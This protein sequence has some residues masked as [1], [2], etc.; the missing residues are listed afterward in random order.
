MNGHKALDG[1][2]NPCTPEQPATIEEYIPSFAQSLIFSYLLTLGEF[3]TDANDTLGWIIFFTASLLS[4]L[5]MLN[6]L[7]AIFSVV[8]D[9][10]T[11]A[12]P[13]H[14]ISAYVDLLS[15]AQGIK[16]DILRQKDDQFDE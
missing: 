11:A 3:S 8:H 9:D 16:K 10:V 12:K 13:K 7:V 14:V 5:I 4:Q 15:D 1:I 2:G 6:L